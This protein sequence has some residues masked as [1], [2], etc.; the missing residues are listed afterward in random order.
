MIPPPPFEAH[1]GQ[2]EDHEVT[3]LWRLGKC[4]IS[5]GHLKSMMVNRERA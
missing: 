2:P 5:Y 3:R 1:S 4:R